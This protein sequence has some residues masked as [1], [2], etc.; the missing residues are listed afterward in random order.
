MREIL[1][2]EVMLIGFT[3]TP[4]LK[5]QKKNAYEDFAKRRK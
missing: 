3:G 1:G 5:D 4:L 2:K